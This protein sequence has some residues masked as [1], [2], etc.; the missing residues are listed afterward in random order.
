MDI[1]IIIL[2]ILLGIFTFILYMI[3][4]LIYTTANVNNSSDIN[5]KLDR[6]IDLLEQQSKE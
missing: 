3:R 6:I 1:I 2:L 5:K 4:R